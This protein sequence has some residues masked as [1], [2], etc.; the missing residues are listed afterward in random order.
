[1]SKYSSYPDYPNRF[2]DDTVGYC[3]F[4]RIR[5]GRRWPI[6]TNRSLSIRL[7]LR[8]VSPEPL[9]L[10]MKPTFYITINDSFLRYGRLRGILNNFN[11]KPR[12]VTP[13]LMEM[14]RNLSVFDA[15][16]GVKL[17]SYLWVLA[18]VA[19]AV[20]IEGAVAGCLAAVA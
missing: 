5:I 3:F 18:A 15:A 7:Q 17:Y 13:K 12:R 14:Y 8:L 16:M 10:R 2:I 1:M 19:V 4:F 20:A 11:A 6:T 9:L